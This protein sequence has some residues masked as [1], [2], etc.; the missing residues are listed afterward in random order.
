MNLLKRFIQWIGTFGS[1]LS[2]VAYVA[3]AEAAF[4]ATI[5]CGWI[6]AVVILG[7]WGITKEAVIDPKYESAPFWWDGFWDLVSYAVGAAA[8]LAYKYL[9]T[10]P[11]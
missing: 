7:P 11:L 10:H 6:G 9:L 5:T 8:G 2:R 3:H 4:I 1:S